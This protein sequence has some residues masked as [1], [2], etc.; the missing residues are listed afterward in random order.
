MAG[1]NFTKNEWHV[2]FGDGPY[3]KVCDL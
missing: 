3:Q 1:R 2:H